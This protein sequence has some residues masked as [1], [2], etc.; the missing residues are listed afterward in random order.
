MDI[1]E[2]KFKNR[3]IDSLESYYEYRRLLNVYKNKYKLFEIHRN[4]NEIK[5]IRKIKKLED[6]INIISYDNI[7]I[8][9]TN[10]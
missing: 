4:D 8:Y 5:F 2:I 10:I 9:Y 7:E 1:L 3:F 6:N